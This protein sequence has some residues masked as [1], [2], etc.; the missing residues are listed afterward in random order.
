[1]IFARN[2]F[3]PNFLG[4]LPSVSYACGQIASQLRIFMTIDVSIRIWALPSANTIVV[5]CFATVRRTTGRVR[6]FCSKTSRSREKYI[7]TKRLN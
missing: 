6:L 4:P 7:R 2:I 3:F 1:M 5:L